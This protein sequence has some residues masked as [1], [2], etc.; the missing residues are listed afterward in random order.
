VLSV[1][2]HPLIV[3]MYI[4]SGLRGDIVQILVEL[5]RRAR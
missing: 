4:D 5:E 2:I 3:G 1:F